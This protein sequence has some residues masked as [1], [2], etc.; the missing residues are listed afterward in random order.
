MIKNEHGVVGPGTLKCLYLNIE[1]MNWADFVLAD[2]N[3]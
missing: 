1:P 2:T 3:L